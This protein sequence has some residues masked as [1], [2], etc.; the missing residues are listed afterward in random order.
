MFATLKN[1]RFSR[2]ASFVAEI[3][4]DDSFQGMVSC[5]QATNVGGNH[6]T[7][8]SLI[9]SLGGRA[10]RENRVYPGPSFPQPDFIQPARPFS[11]AEVL[12]AKS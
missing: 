9:L 2:M 5:R 6:Y 7:N 3:A 12:C 11:S 8:R 10:D 1:T 4:I